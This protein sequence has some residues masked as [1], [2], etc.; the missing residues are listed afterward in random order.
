MVSV[1]RKGGN[2]HKKKYR[3]FHFNMRRIFAVGMIELWNRLC[4]GVC[5]LKGAQ[6][7]SGYGPIQPA[8]V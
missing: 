6:N 5:V 7:L 1:D 3:N 8:L 2:E 4:C